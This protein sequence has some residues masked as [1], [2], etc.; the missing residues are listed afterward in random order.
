[1][2]SLFESYASLPMLAPA[3]LLCAC[4]ISVVC[5]RI[6]WLRLLSQQASQLRDDYG[7]NA[8]LLRARYGTGHYAAWNALRQQAEP[9]LP[10]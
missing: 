9:L 10:R 6:Y 7:Q 1:M 4:A 3:V 8:H 5:I 2:N